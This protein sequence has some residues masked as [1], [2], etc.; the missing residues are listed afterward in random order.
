MKKQ[1]IEI[2]PELLEKY[3]KK[4]KQ[5]RKAVR[6]GVDKDLKLFTQSVWEW[7]RRIEHLQK[8]KYTDEEINYYLASDLSYE[9]GME[10][11]WQKRRAEDK[12]QKENEPQNLVLDDEDEE[13][14][15]EDEY[16]EYDEPV[17]KIKHTIVKKDTALTI[18]ERSVNYLFGQL[19][20]KGVKKYLTSGQELDYKLMWAV[21][22]LSSEISKQTG[23]SKDKKGELVLFR[24]AAMFFDFLSKKPKTF[25]PY[26]LK[27][28]A[29]EARKWLGFSSNKMSLKNVVDLFRGLQRV[30]FE[31]EGERIL[32]DAEK[33][34]WV[35][36]TVSSSLYSMKRV[37]L[38][39]I[40][41]NRWKTQD[42]N[43]FLR[44]DSV[45]GWM[46]LGNL[47]CGRK[48]RITLPKQARHELTG[49]Q[50]NILRELRLWKKP[51]P[52]NIFELAKI[53]GYKS[54]ETDKLRKSLV[55]ALEG[56]KQ[57]QYIKDFE[58]TG[59]GKKIKFKI[60][61]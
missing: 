3:K 11:R 56:L 9:L 55:K 35:E 21:D 54:K 5:I 48:G 25:E 20:I 31:A 45:M 60:F 29:S 50:Q 46:F 33:G 1:N 7:K 32:R 18:S 47:S 49:Y 19:K 26:I 13:E 39:R 2:E 41:S 14:D 38:K 34:K 59:K 37:S 57:K 12:K 27:F 24:N 28:K 44:F 52:Y 23:I 15:D 10:E 16:D 58:P 43:L 61:K 30:I 53:A 51:K 40:I 4:V 8:D 17:T 22:F 6:D 36:T 42:V